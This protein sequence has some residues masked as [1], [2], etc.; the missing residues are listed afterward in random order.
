MALEL[1]LSW[2]ILMEEGVSLESGDRGDEKK[3][4]RASVFDTGKHEV[5]SLIDNPHVHR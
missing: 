4:F 5:A 3:H 2:E 1:S